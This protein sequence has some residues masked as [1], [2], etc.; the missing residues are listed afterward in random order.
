MI[1]LLPSENPCP[2]NRVWLGPRRADE[3]HAMLYLVNCRYFA[4]V[5]FIVVGVNCEV[6]L[7][8][9]WENRKLP[10]RCCWH[11]IDMTEPSGIV[12]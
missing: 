10:N 9:Q 3:G 6:V 5:W 4:A 11:D 12:I 7:I 2:F 1:T 8:E